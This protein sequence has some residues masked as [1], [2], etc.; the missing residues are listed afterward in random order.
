[1]AHEIP[2]MHTAGP[3][4][5]QVV[6]LA[7]NPE[8]C[9]G[10]G[11]RT[12]RATEDLLFFGHDAGKHPSAR[13]TVLEVKHLLAAAVAECE[14]LVDTR[15]HVVGDAVPRERF[16]GWCFVIELVQLNWVSDIQ[17]EPVE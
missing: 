13:G 9:C 1:M 12:T 7:D 15:R 4:L 2:D 6:G 10:S 11:F 16:M 14:D 8:Q 17:S 3:L 5:E